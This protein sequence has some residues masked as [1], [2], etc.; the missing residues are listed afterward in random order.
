MSTSMKRVRPVFAV[1]DAA[2]GH[3]NDAVDGD[4][5]RLLLDAAGFLFI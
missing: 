1:G 4:A 2:D 5:K 3:H